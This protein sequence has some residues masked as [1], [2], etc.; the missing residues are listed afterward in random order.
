[1]NPLPPSSKT[2][3]S[4]LEQGGLMSYKDIVNKCS[5]SP[6]AVRYALKKLKEHDL[7]VEK[8]NIRDM[9]QVLYLGRSAL[10]QKAKVDGALSDI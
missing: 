9:R 1:M 7:I 6:R 2:V 8:M 3:L 5:Y 4:I 10:L